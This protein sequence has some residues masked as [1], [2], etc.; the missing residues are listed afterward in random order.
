MNVILLGP[1]RAGRAISLGLR[2]AG[3]TI[4]GVLARDPEAAVAAASELE[5]Q[6]LVWGETLPAADLVV[7][8]VRDDAIA[9]V[10]SQIGPLAHD[11]SGAVHLSGITPVSALDGL[12]GPMIG[13]FHP[14]QTLPTAEI[15]AARLEG[16]WVAVTSETDFFAD[17][18]FSLARSLGMHP[19]ELDDTAKAVYHA[20]AAAAANYPIAALALAERLFAAAGVPFEA[21]SPL[22]AAVIDNAM[23]IGPGAALTGPIA[24]GDVG[25]VSTQIEAVRQVAPDLVE[26][27]MAM[28]RAVAE[29]A[30]SDAEMDE[31]LR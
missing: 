26:H 28:G 27:F 31:V 17:R 3:H 18:L 11:V 20:A 15:G 30:G 13:S 4:V 21:A 10:A 6:P 9:A 12:T 25:T 19:F 7:I 5:T 16:A 1:G 24:R 29:V 22:V 8:A 23:S 2:S 14:L